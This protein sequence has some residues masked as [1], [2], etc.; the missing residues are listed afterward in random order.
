MIVGDD[1]TKAAGRGG[2]ESV[3]GEVDSIVAWGKYQAQLS[4]GFGGDFAEGEH[5]R[6]NEVVAKQR[7]FRWEI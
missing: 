5:K 3:R 4:E 6:K 7:R 2:C 1:G